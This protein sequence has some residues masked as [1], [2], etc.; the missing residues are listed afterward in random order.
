MQV[1]LAIA[2]QPFS[3]DKFHKRPSQ[4]VR[5]ID[6]PNQRILINERTSP[7]IDIPC[8]RTKQDNQS[9]IDFAN[10]FFLRMQNRQFKIF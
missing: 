6:L 9:I 3:L 8:D 10:M 7:V 2:K 4:V 1:G 5:D